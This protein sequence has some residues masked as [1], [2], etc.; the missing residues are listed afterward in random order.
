MLVQDPSC[1]DGA[2]GVPDHLKLEEKLDLIIAVVSVC[3]FVCLRG[4]Q[5]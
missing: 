3:S 5:V 2:L 4:L 1:R